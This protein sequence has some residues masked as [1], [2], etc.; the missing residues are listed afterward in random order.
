[1]GLYEGDDESYLERLGGLTKRLKDLKALPAQ[2][3][4]E[5]IAL[6]E[7]YGESWKTLDAEQRRTLLLDSRIKVFVG[8]GL[9][10]EYFARVYV[11]EEIEEFLSA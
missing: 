8:R 2:A 4:F 6:G 11:P 1:L 5:W 3:G 9:G 10:N 7:T